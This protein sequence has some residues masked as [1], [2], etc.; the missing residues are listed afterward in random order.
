MACAWV[1]RAA[2]PTL[3]YLA[4]NGLVAERMLCVFPTLTFPNHYSIATGLYPA[5]E[6]I[7]ANGMRV[8][9]C[10]SSSRTTR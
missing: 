2:T 3:D 9:L 1:A 10:G 5:E 7:V 6:G 4:E 8:S